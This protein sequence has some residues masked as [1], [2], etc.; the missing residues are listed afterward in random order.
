MF[1]ALLYIRLR[2]HTFWR[3]ASGHLSL[4]TPQVQ[5]SKLLRCGNPRQAQQSPA[6]PR[7]AQARQARLG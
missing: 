3:L 5:A 6:R 1:Q 4:Q 2:V 7:R